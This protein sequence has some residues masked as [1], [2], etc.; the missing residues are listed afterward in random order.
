MASIISAL[1]AAGD[2]VEGSND[3][4]QTG[5][6]VLIGMQS[7]RFTKPCTYMHMDYACDDQEDSKQTSQGCGPSMALPVASS[8]SIEE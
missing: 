5:W 6:G 1:K 4:M 3:P 2:V 8:A 7:R